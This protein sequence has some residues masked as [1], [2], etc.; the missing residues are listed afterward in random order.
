MIAPSTTIGLVEINAVRATEDY[1]ETGSFNPNVITAK[2]YNP[3]SELINYG[4]GIGNYA[5]ADL[6]LNTQ[7]WERWAGSSDTRPVN[8]RRLIEALTVTQDG[9]TKGRFSYCH[10]FETLPRF[11]KSSVNLWK[12]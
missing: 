1:W 11:L 9:I 5:P 7:V 10:V 3:D 2:A 12:V 4:G 6:Y 8:D